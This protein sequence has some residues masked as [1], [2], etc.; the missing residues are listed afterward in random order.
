[1]SEVTQI[2]LGIL[3]GVCIVT[4]YEF[5]QAWRGDRAIERNMLEWAGKRAQFY[6]EFRLREEALAAKDRKTWDSIGEPYSIGVDPAAPNS[7]KTVKTC[8]K[9]GYVSSDM[10][11]KCPSCP[12]WRP[13]AKI[14]AHTDGELCTFMKHDDDT[15]VICKGYDLGCVGY[16]PREDD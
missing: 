12:G 1:M 10:P 9:C 11:D 13:R 4:L 5:I 3:L 6:A 8:V 14:C 16:I 15:P 7:D 2:L